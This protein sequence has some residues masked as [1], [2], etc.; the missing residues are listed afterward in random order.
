MT[1][2]GKILS[3]QLQ[4]LMMK[5]TLKSPIQLARTQMKSLLEKN[6]SSFLAYLMMMIQIFKDSE[7]TVTFECDTNG[8]FQGQQIIKIK[9]FIESS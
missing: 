3:V 2:Y 6:G 7:S 9:L 5:M 4:N 1:C 8:P